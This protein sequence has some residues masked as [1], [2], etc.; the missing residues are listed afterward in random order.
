MFIHCRGFRREEAFELGHR[1]ERGRFWRE[2]DAEQ[3]SGLFHYNRKSFSVGL[4]CYEKI[5]IFWRYIL[6]TMENTLVH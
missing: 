6:M 1:L 4:I 3:I 5:L 2:F